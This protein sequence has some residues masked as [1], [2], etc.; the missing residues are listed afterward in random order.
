MHLHAGKG[1]TGGRTDQVRQAQRGGTDKYRRVFQFRKLVR[2]RG[3]QHVR[4][5]DIGNPAAM[6][7]I[8]NQ[9]PAVLVRE[10]LGVIQP[11]RQHPLGVLHRGRL[12]L[13]SHGL[14]V[15]AGHRQ[16][17]RRIDHIAVAQDQRCAPQYAV[18]IGSGIEEAA[19]FRRL[20]QRGQVA[21]V[22]GHHRD[23]EVFMI[24]LGEEGPAGGQCAHRCFLFGVKQETQYHV[25]A[26]QLLGEN[27]IAVHRR[28]QLLQI[29]H[30]L[31]SP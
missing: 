25:L 12:H 16:G 27:C 28:D 2:L 15:T 22:T 6:A 7:G 5:G 17:Q 20:L 14:K 10:D 21:G 4:S 30:M 9:H 11:Q 8:G 3:L 24:R 31:K 26:L 18:G 1:R 29:L 19:V 23:G 13:E